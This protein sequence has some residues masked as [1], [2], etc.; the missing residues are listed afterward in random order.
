MGFRSLNID[1]IIYRIHDFFFQPLW[2]VI[3]LQWI[4]NSKSAQLLEQTNQLGVA[5]QSSFFDKYFSSGLFRIFSSRPSVNNNSVE[6]LLNPTDGRGTLEFI[7]DIFFGRNDKESV[8]D[9]LFSTAFGWIVIIAIVSFLVHLFFKQKMNFLS[10]KEKIIY[11]IAHVSEEKKVSN[12]KAS[13]WQE[14]LDKVNSTEE[15]SWKIA[16]MDAEI[17]LEEVLIEQGYNGAGVAERLKQVGPEFKD[18]IQ[19]AWEGHK[20]RNSV[21]HDAAFRLSQKEAR[22]AVS[23]YERFFSAFYR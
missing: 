10:E 22:R 9:L 8:I 12:D 11:D 2:H 1:E 19:Y 18:V 13:R 4:F 16:I 6:E 17:L 21:A 7:L 3:S 14:I 23:V 15:T 20:V 5:V